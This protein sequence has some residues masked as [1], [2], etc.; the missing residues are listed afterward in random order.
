MVHNCVREGVIAIASSILPVS[1][2][3]MGVLKKALS[4]GFE[5]VVR[6]DEQLRCDGRSLQDLRTFGRSPHFMLSSR[7]GF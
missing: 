2:R 5:I 7:A 3:W 1:V 6:S 4:L